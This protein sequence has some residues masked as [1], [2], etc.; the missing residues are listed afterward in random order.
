MDLIVFIGALIVAFLVFTWL[1]NV[2]RATVS[3]AITVA[4][5]VLILQIF[6]GV[7]HTAILNA[8][9]DMWNAIL[10]AFQ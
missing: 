7:N 3:A 5:V 2:M 4:I 10:N 1:V 6:F 8:L 9:S